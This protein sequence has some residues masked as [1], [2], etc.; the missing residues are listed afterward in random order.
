MVN[1]R[2]AEIH[3]RLQR[4][5]VASRVLRL[6]IM[7]SFGPYESG[8]VWVVASVNPIGIGFTDN[9]E[10]HWAA[11]AN[12]VAVRESAAYMPEQ[13]QVDMRSTLPD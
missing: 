7:P 4:V 6:V 11:P 13:S 5:A 9:I 10:S 2:P 8:S 1:N 12:P 3:P